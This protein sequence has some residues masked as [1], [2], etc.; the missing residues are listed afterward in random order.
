MFR[1]IALISM[2]WMLICATPLAAE[3]FEVVE[4]GAPGKTA[5]RDGHY[6][7]SPDGLHVA[8]IEPG[9]AGVR[10]ARRNGGDPRSSG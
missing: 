3:P 8:Y 1:V 2:L 10:S 6:W 7:V 9:G 5:L 4:V